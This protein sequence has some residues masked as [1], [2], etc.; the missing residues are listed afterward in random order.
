M[1]LFE[2]LFFPVLN[3]FSP[4]KCSSLTESET[5]STG[6]MSTFRKDRAASSPIRVIVLL[7]LDV[8]ESTMLPKRPVNLYDIRS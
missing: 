4:D 7:D 8:A 1:R 6:E 3:H 5:V 2:R